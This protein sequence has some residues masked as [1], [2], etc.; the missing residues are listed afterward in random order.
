MKKGLYL[1]LLLAIAFAGCKNNG[2]KLIKVNQLPAV[3]TAHYTKVLWL[4]S[5]VDFGVIKMGEK[6]NI[7]FRVKNT[8]TKPLYLTDVHPVCGCTVAD[9]T[10]EAIAPG[11]EG[12][13]VGAFDSKLSHVG[14]VR[15]SILATTNSQNGIN[16]NLIFTGVINE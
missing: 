6:I 5:L 14:T 16:H 3:D 4:D 1:A 10:K 9:Y 15:K 2:E 8:G 13:V 11:A 7:R 12:V